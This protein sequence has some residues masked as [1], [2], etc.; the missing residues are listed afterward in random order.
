VKRAIAV[1]TGSRAEY[2]ILRPLLRLLARDRRVELRLL[3]TG[4][5]LRPEFGSTVREIRR[6]GFR[7]TALVPIL[8]GG[9]LDARAVARATARAVDG[10]SRVF[11][12]SSPDLLVLIGDR[13][14]TLGA[15]TAALAHR[16][17]VAHI[18]GGK[19]TV[20]VI[21]ESIR[22]AVT[23]LSHYHFTH[24]AVFRARLLRMGERP[25]R[26]FAYGSPLVDEI[27]STKASSRAATLRACGLTGLGRYLVV[28]VHAETLSEVPAG[29]L[30]DAVLR[31]AA[32]SGL[33]LVLTYPGAEAGSGE[34]TA[35]LKAFAAK[36]GARLLSSLPR[37]LFLDLLRHS[38]AL[39]GN[40]SAGITD[41]PSL[42][43]P[44]VNAGGRQDGMLKAAN[45]IDCAASG[46]AVARAVARALTPAFRARA[47]KARNPYGDG[48]AVPRIAR[49]LAT[50]P[51][52]PG[53]VRKP[54][55]DGVAR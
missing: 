45:V 21:D 48:R 10:F 35:A 29:R 39:V 34:I 6:D 26:V 28:A 46:P 2:G 17:P 14:E 20:G 55:H 18:S 51:L 42:G 1:V 9:R 4:A 52:G 11:A 49:A 23:K 43:L 7:P 47:R 24:N 54:F 5:H 12:R 16:V 41:A 53:V 8:D 38:E 50:L 37:A 31:G 19:T 27:V 13:Y 3:V 15:A 40:S 32:R 30:T 36:R 22:H 33:D 44:A 25:E